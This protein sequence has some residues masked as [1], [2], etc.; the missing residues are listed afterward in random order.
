M[1]QLRMLSLGLAHLLHGVAENAKQMEQ[2][3][4]QV[5]AE[6]NGAAKSL[7]SLRKQSLQAGRTHKQVRGN[8]ISEKSNF[9]HKKANQRAKN[10]NFTLF[11]ENTPTTFLSAYTLLAVVNF[12]EMILL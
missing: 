9:T 6:L 1:S 2:Q 5:S 4:Q 10:P 7:E 11:L 3:G 12:P 8:P